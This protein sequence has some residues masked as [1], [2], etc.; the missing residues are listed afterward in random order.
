M[1]GELVILPRINHFLTLLL[2]ATSPNLPRHEESNP[3]F[4]HILATI[5]KVLTPGG[6]RALVAEHLLLKQQ[7]LITERLIGPIRREL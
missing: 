6:A 4:H 7:L 5:A 1:H 2:D 3:G